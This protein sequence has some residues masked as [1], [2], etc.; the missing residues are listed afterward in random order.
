MG[1]AWTSHRRAMLE[2]WTRSKEW[3]LSSLAKVGFFTPTGSVNYMG[4]L[5][6]N[7]KPDLTNLYAGIG[8]ACNWHHNDTSSFAWR[9]AKRFFSSRAN[10]GGLA[11]KGSG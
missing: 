4:N 3:I 2:Y 8:Y 9:K 7:L 6:D 5:N 11:P 10:V 1:Y